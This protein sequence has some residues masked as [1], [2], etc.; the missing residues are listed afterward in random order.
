M[1]CNLIYIRTRIPQ[2]FNSGLSQ[3]SY[4]FY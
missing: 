4:R 1:D 2:C 3:T